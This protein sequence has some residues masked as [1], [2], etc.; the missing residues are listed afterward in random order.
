MNSLLFVVVLASSVYFFPSYNQHTHALSVCLDFVCN[1]EDGTGYNL[2]HAQMVGG[3]GLSSWTYNSIVAMSTS[4]TGK[5]EGPYEFTREVLPHFAHNPTIRKAADGT[6]V[7][8]FIGG[9]PTV[10]KKCDGDT[11]AEDSRF[12]LSDATCVSN[13][14]YDDP[15]TIRVGA[16][17][18][19][20]EL[21]I[22][23]T[24]KDCA[25]SC[26]NDTKCEAFSFN[27]NKNTSV[28]PVCKHKSQGAVRMRC[29]E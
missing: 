10:A 8:Y 11:N 23:A 2:F 21:A 29:N 27:I 28:A 17:Y 13:T 26:C 20:V 6:Y 15:S 16:D 4:T 12:E 19:T 3:C 25:A 22:N 9:W 5:V 14:T 1:Q 24:I 18:A 7:I